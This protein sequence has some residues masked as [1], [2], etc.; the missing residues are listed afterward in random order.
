MAD[1]DSLL[2]DASQ[3]PLAAQ[4]QLIEALWDTVPED[5]VS[6]LSD[7]WI[8]EIDRRSDEHDAGKVQT[9]PWGQIRT[10]RC[11]EK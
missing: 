10:T 7:E 11:G 3:L 1:Y 5:A 6:A 8:T 4:I 2:S 9:I